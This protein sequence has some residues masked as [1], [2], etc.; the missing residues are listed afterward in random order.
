MTKKEI[1]KIQQSAENGIAAD[2]QKWAR[3]LYW[4]VDEIKQDHDL[5]AEYY[6][7]SLVQ[8]FDLANKGFLRLLESEN[9]TAVKLNTELQQKKS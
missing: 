4:G 1:L 8:G 5:S 9:P 3:I 2:Q 6:Y 7:K